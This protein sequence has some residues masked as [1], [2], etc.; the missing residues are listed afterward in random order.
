MN[1]HKRR[2]NTTDSSRSTLHDKKYLPQQQ[3]LQE[4][5]GYQLGLALAN[6][7]RTQQTAAETQST[8]RNVYHNSRDKN[9][10][11]TNLVWHLQTKKEHNRQ[12]QTHN[13]RQEMFTTAGIARTLRIPS[14]FGTC[15]G[16]RNLQGGRTNKCG[17]YDGCRWKCRTLSGQCS[18][19]VREESKEVHQAWT[20]SAP[21]PP[22]QDLG[23]EAVPES[24]RTPSHV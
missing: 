12:Q 4:H 13:P 16:A 20:S 22:S 24:A 6:E 14:W 17:P 15:N 2:K 8:T 9:T 3:G 18:H 1:Q 7:E 21:H 5:I 23:S 19:L 10:S 11:D